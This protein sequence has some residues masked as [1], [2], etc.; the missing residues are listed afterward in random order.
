MQYLPGK[1]STAGIIMSKYFLHDGQN[2]IG[3]FDKSELKD[4]KIAS[5]T[6]V[7][8]EPLTDW[9]TAGEIEE[10][11]D[12]FIVILMKCLNITVM[13]FIKLVKQQILNQECQVILQVI[14]N[15]VY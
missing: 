15:H 5:D 1:I 4:K 14:L 3:P 6:P 12:L 13:I 10:L 8:Y 2:Q 11:K 7:W 9:T